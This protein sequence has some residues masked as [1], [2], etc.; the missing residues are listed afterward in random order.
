MYGLIYTN[1]DFLGKGSDKD[2]TNGTHELW[3]LED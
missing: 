3:S 2:M 1:A